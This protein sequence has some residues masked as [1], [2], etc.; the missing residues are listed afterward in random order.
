[1]RDLAKSDD[2]DFP[3]VRKNPFVEYRLSFANVSF[4]STKHIGKDEPFLF[5]VPV[6]KELYQHPFS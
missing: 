1:M 4:F 5:T 6:V 2:P 3:V